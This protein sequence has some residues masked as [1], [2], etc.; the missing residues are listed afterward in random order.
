MK[1]IVLEA[2]INEYAM[3]DGN[4]HIPFTTEEIVETALRCREEGASILHF[5]ARQVDGSPE[6]SLNAYAETIRKVREKCDIL[7]L[8]TLGFISNEGANPK[9]RINKMLKLAEDSATKPDI[10]PIDMGSM[11]FE[12]YNASERKLEQ[13]DQVYINS[14]AT[15]QH[16]AVELRHAGIKPKMTC[17]DTGF[18]RRAGTFLEMGLVDHPGYVLFL[19]S[20][21]KH[22][23]G[24]PGTPAGLEAFLSFLP[25]G[26]EWTTGCFGGNLINLAPYVVRRGGH[27]AVGIGDYP[28]KE[29]GQPTNEEIVRMAVDIAKANGREIASP[30]DARE[31]L[32]IL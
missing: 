20:E 16:F 10:V 5:H 28:Y 19:L 24:I 17:W 26:C 4:P 30:Q 22:R 6:H 1:K 2:R 25:E 15:L 29:L 11:N 8:P 21:G 18:I 12:L 31:I 9:D 13:A 32:G 27:L 7:I 3:R 23:A 14:A